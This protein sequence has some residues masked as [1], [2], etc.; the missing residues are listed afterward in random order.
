MSTHNVKI[1]A[2]YIKDLSFELPAAPQIFAQQQTRPDIS[3]SIDIDAK[4]ISEENFEI[5]LKIKADSKVGE[6]QFFICELLY[7]GIF[8]FGKI[9]ENLLEQI[10]LIY[11]PNLLFPFVRRIITNISTDA[12]LAPLMLDPIDFA[13]L[14][15]RRKKVSNATPISNLKN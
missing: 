1:L 3:I 10:L 2:Q 7:C 8:S 11:C 6:Q 5:G 14:Y 15:N 4:K 9:E 13:E 12:G